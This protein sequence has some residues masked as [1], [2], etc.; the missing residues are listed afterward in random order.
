[1]LEYDPKRRILPFNALQASFFKRTYDE[2]SSTINHPPLSTANIL[3]TNSSNNGTNNVNSLLQQNNSLIS[4]N[5]NIPSSSNLN[6]N[7]SPNLD[8]SKLNKK[9]NEKILS[10]NSLR[11]EIKSL[12]N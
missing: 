5:T 4:N 6:S 7:G 1:M 10:I 8:P 2:T 12:S 3:L 11:F 9:K